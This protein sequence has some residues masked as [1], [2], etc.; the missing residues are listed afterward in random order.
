MIPRQHGSYE[1][2]GEKLQTPVD[3]VDFSVV[4]PVYGCSSCLYELHERLRSSLRTI[5]EN[6]EII[7]V[8]D[9]SPTASWEVICELSKQDSRVRGI[10]LSRNFG[11]HY[12]IT[13]GLDFSRGDWVVVM[14]CDLQD[15]PEEIIKLYR[16]AQEGFDLVVGRRINRQDGYFKK[17]GSR[18]FNLI[19]DYFTGSQLDNRIGNFGLYSKRVVN[20]IRSMREQ[21]RSFGLFAYWV[22]F[23]RAEI[24]IIHAARKE[25]RSGYT[26]RRLVN[27][28][29]D[30]IV[31]HSNALLMLTIKTGFLMAVGSVLFSLWLAVR[32]FISGGGVTGWTSLMVS[33]Y[34]TAGL[35]IT[36]IGV[37]GLYIGKIFNEVKGRPLYI[38]Q[39]TTFDPE[40]DS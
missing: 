26:L 13:A 18:W 38:V 12:A 6:Y 10:N 40:Q 2:S 39:S 37:V 21:N 29:I 24:D 11:Q 34:F 7:L 4:V 19:F 31:A 16:K 22:G 28:A 8:N 23:R 35:M 3:K 30:S 33:I 17:L 1:R 25:G 32:Y 27:L 5:T 15:Q 9:A 14:D 36:C 20:S